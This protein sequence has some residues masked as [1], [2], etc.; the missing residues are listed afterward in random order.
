MDAQCGG[1]IATD[2]MTAIK[3]AFIDPMASVTAPI[4]TWLV[5][6]VVADLAIAL[7]LVCTLYRRKE[8]VS[9]VKQ[10]ER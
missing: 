1:A 6:T 8:L 7:A 10:T 2:V 3:S 9:Q 5:A 4:L